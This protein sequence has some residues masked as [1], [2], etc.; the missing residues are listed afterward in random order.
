MTGPT[1]LQKLIAA[2]GLASRREAERWI[3]AGRVSVNGRPVTRPG[4]TADPAMDRIEVDGCPLPATPPLRYVLLHKPAGVLT[5]RRDLRGRRVVFDLLPDLGVRLHAVGRLDADTEGLLLLTNHGSLTYRLTHPRYGVRRRY[6]AWVDG[7]VPDAALRQL[8]R[9]VVLEDGLARPESV[10]RLPTAGAGGG[11]ELVLREGRYRE[12]RRL[13]R[14]VGLR[15]HRLV[16]VGF[17]PLN[18]GA[19]P[20]GAWRELTA[21]EVAALRA[22]DPNR[23]GD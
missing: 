6:Q 7:P 20:P 3:L 5:T 18:L 11:L 17:G 15:V 2:A 14:A 19:L 21:R 13:L 1:R 10:R 4:A 23:A 8:R 22:L 9:G 16:R 12:V